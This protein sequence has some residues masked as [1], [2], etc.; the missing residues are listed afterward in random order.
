MGRIASMDSL[1]PSRSSVRMREA[2]M[3]SAE[4]IA[5]DRRKFKLWGKDTGFFKNK[6][7]GKSQGMRYC[8]K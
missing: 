7:R 5:F 8:C 1:P 6:I 2:S 3:I 4:V